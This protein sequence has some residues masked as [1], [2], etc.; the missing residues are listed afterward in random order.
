MR[1]IN[2]AI[3]IYLAPYLNCI[4]AVSNI[5]YITTDN[6]I[7]KTDK[8]L[9][10]IG[11]YLSY[12]E[13][14]GLCYYSPSNTI[15]VASYSGKKIFELSTALATVSSI[16]TGKYLPASIQDFNGKL[17]VGTFDG[18]ILVI[19]NRIISQVLQGCNSLLDTFIAASILFDNYGY[20]A[21]NCDSAFDHYFAV[22]FI[23]GTF[24]GNKLMT[25]NNYTYSSDVRFDSL[26]RLIANSDNQISIFS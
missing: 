3:G 22:F 11:Y 4:I 25:P 16:S 20:M 21:V 14:I 7:Y 5:L 17:Y 15:F 23:N 8:Y 9:N 12:M 18:Y 26:G 2:L 19:L 13:Y 6:G 10:V 24:T 1:G